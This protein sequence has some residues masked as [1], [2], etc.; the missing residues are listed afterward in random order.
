M[1]DT[2]LPLVNVKDILCRIGKSWNYHLWV[3]IVDSTPTHMMHCRFRRIIQ[4]IQ[5]WDSWLIWRS[6]AWASWEPLSQHYHGWLVK[7]RP[8]VSGWIDPISLQLQQADWISK[9]STNRTPYLFHGG[10]GRWRAE[11]NET[12]CHM[13]WLIFKSANSATYLIKCSHIFGTSSI[14][15]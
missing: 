14:T 10:L 5:S 11:G 7:E 6:G 15:I 12:N 8:A 4:Y 13:V 9:S 2:C 1:C 3:H